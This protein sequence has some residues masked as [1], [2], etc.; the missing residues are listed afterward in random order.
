MSVQNISACDERRADI[1]AEN[2]RR[3]WKWMAKAIG[4]TTSVWR[5]EWIK[6]SVAL[7]EDSLD[8]LPSPTEKNGQLVPR[9]RIALA[10]VAGFFVALV[11]VLRQRCGGGQTPLPPDATRI[12]AS[13]AEWST[14]TRH[15]LTAIDP[16]DPPISAVILLGRL[17][18]TS[19]QTAELWESCRPGSR[20]ASLPLVVPMS[21]RACLAALGDLPRLFREGLASSGYMLLALSFREQ[22]AISFRVVLGNVAAHW[23]KE[24]GAASTSE[25][26]FG[27]TGTADTTLL[28]HA[29]QRTGGRS[30]H[31]VHG[32]AIGPNFLGL[33]DLGLFRSR[34]DA[35][36]YARL[37]AYGACAVQE[38]PAMEPRRGEAGL[39]LLS[40]LAHPMNPG[41]QRFG[42]RDEASLLEA[43][44]DAARLLGA[45]AQPLRWKPHPVIA[46]LPPD[47]VDALRA[48]AARHGFE[49]LP[50]DMPVE[51]IA[52]SSRWV[53][54]SPSTVA[55]DLL[56][57][58]YLSIVL[59]P[60]G[61]V[62][63]T[64]LVGLPGAACDPQPL[65][66]LCRDLD[67]QDSYAGAWAAAIETIGP[68]RALD[69]RA[70][71]E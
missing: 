51:Q 11:Y 15:L 34:H 57:A 4:S 70:R 67:P 55:L 35:R 52:E 3:A 5:L 8:P 33:S 69:L 71:L 10:M 24:C 31:A 42:L 40:N 26:I 54:T 60:Q 37:G 22:V 25:V 38:G 2:R 13:H 39:S 41:F 64:A 28:E 59:D 27:M 23:W 61:T 62:L 63:D 7:A 17:R 14:R 20:A 56:R 1:R 50:P 44:G 53:V 12:A 19:D 29:I 45:P 18:R 16:A 66:A 21:P 9:W 48:C 58:G 43:V 6:A 49:E 46:D 68:A 32:Q 65:A 47:T 36:A 30:V